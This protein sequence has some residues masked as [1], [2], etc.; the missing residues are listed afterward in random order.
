MQ[1]RIILVTGSTDGIGYQTAIELVKLNFHVIIHGRNQ[2]KAD[3]T[4]KRIA[5]L[6]QRNN[7][8]AVYA[9]LRSFNQI[10]KMIDD[11]KSRFN[12]LDV[13]INNAG[14]YKPERNI[15]EEGFETTF[16]VN[17]L[18]PFL[19]T[20]L[21]MKSLKKSDSSRIVNVA[22]RVHSNNFDLKNLQ[23][24]LGYTGVKAY[25][26][27]KTALILFTYFLASKL[28]KSNITVNCLHPGVIDTKL[29]RSA[30]GSYGAPVLEGAK[31][32][33]FA[34]TALKLEHVTGKYLVNN[35]PESSKDITYDKEKQNALWYKTKELIGS[36]FDLL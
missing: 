30:Y 13:L 14:V 29:L 15:T 25:A 31:T 24:E 3:L 17:Y 32:L 21:L 9:D 23:F 5:R 7:L 36:K 22:S 11:I 1:E 4:L 27:S 20:N 35:H 34:A 2:E 18:A 16:A 28:K 12:R 33:I 8:S 19:L 10:K 6:T 26:Q